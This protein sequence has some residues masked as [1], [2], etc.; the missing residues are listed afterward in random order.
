MT[1]IPLGRMRGQTMPRAHYGHDPVI[2]SRTFLPAFRLLCL[3]CDVGGRISDDS[4]DETGALGR[5]D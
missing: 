4:I 3:Y 2:C 5:Q 1:L